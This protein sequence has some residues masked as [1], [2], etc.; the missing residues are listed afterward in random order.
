MKTMLM[1]LVGLLLVAAACT[2]ETKPPRSETIG[3]V[4]GVLTGSVTIGPLCP[5]EPCA[6]GSDVYSGREL[7]L[8]QPGGALLLVPLRSN[9]T[10]EAVISTGSYTVDLDSCATGE[11]KTQL[12]RTTPNGSPIPSTS[13]RCFEPSFQSFALGR[14][15]SRYA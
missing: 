6:D 9:G 4:R 8:Q 15:L 11:C 12:T 3:D 1:G 13:S 10:F 7:V 14:H 5:V 2:G